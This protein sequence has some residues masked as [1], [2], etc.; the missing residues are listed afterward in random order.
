VIVVEAV[1]AT[2][3]ELRPIQSGW[4]VVHWVVLLPLYVGFVGFLAFGLV[5]LGPDGDAYAPGLLFVF[6]GGTV[7]AWMAAYRLAAAVG[8]RAAGKAPASG[9][10]WRWTI[11]ADS[12]S[13][14]SALQSSRI[15]WRAIKAVREEA[16]RFVFLLLPGTNPVLPK[17]LL[18]EGQVEA[19]RGLI[20][21]LRARGVLGAGVD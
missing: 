14:E 17:R 3:R 9:L 2:P 10:D 15:D 4:G 6:F 18:S 19:V 21:D 7:I 12:L 11:S 5:A 8:A 16:D 1:K 13:F 20:D